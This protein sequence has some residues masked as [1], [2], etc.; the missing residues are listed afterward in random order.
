MENIELLLRARWCVHS[1]DYR[2]ELAK[3]LRVQALSEK[4]Y[5]INRVTFFPNCVIVLRLLHTAA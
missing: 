3:A 2:L 4:V 5:Q 1:A